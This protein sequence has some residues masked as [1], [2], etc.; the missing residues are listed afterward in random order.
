MVP[1]D[2]KDRPIAQKKTQLKLYSY[3]E[4]EEDEEE[5][6]PQKAK[7]PKKKSPV[8]RRAPGTRQRKHT[9]RLDPSQIS[10][11]KRF[12]EYEL[13]KIVADRIRKG[14][15]E[16][17]V[18]WKGYSAEDDTWEPYSNIKNTA[19]YKAYQKNMKKKG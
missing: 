6:K 15:Q 2:G 11:K 12:T 16:F 18:R 3:E 19:G 14:K 4:D 13:D 10:E 17:K 1:K 9:Q 5:T 7:T 8:K